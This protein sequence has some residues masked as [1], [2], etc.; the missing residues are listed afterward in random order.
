MYVLVCVLNSENK[1]EKTERQK[2][3]RKQQGAQ[4]KEEKKI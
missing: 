2:R 3:G 4:R 1:K